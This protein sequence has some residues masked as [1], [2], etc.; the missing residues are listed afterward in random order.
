[1][2]EDTHQ[3][4]LMTWARKMILAGRPELKR[5]FAIPNG[6][7]RGKG[8][9]AKLKAM[10]VRAGVADL[11]LAA[12]QQTWRADGSEWIVGGLWIEMKAPGGDGV[13]RG[14]VSAE[15]KNWLEE[16]GGDY[17]TAVCYGW[18][19]AVQAIRGYLGGEWPEIDMSECE[20]RMGAGQE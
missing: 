18:E 20:R 9:A 15:Q 14:V 5:L 8:E 2:T 17:A 10:G 7:L 1:M 3:I 13:K 12:P 11:F 16:V 6:G 19:A 4:L